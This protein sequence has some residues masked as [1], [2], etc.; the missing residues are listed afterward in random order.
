MC[1]KRNLS[2]G[3]IQHSITR[4]DASQANHPAALANVTPGFALTG[5]GAEVHTTGNGSLLF[6]LEPST[7]NNPTFDA[8]SADH[9]LPDPTTLTAYALGI[10]L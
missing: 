7:D 10:R 4:A 9:K 1:L 8:A 2:V 6:R 3:R 5:G